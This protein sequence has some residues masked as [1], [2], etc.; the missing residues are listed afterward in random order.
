ME[1]LVIRILPVENS[2]DSGSKGLFFFNKKTLNKIKEEQQKG[3]NVS[4][5]TKTT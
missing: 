4:V 5:S 3:E 1:D 2:G